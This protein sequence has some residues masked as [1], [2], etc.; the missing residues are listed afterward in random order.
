MGRLVED[1]KEA[2]RELRFA[3]VAG[4]A[5]LMSVVG[6][7]FL[8]SGILY[9]NHT[10]R[11]LLFTVSPSSVSLTVWGYVA[12][13]TANPTVTILQ[14]NVTAIRRFH[15]D[16][17]DDY[18]VPTLT[19][20]LSTMEEI[21]IEL[22]KYYGAISPI[23]QISAY[24]V[25]RYDTD[26]PIENA[27]KFYREIHPILKRLDPD[28]FFQME[29]VVLLSGGGGVLCEWV[30][31]NEA[32]DDDMLYTL[33]PLH[34]SDS[35]VAFAL[36]VA[37]PSD[38]YSLVELH[39]TDYTVRARGTD[40]YSFDRG[41]SFYDAFLVVRQWERYVGTVDSVWDACIPLMTKRV[42]N[43]RL[44]AY[45]SDVLSISEEINVRGT[46]NVFDCMEKLE[47]VLSISPS[48][49]SN[50]PVSR[51]EEQ[52]FRDCVRQN[53]PSF[54]RYLPGSNMTDAFCHFLSTAT[55]IDCLVLNT[56]APTV[57]TLNGFAVRYCNDIVFPCAF[58]WQDLRSILK[59]NEYQ[60]PPVVIFTGD[61]LEAFRVFPSIQFAF[62]LD[63]AVKLIY[64]ARVCNRGDTSNRTGTI[65][66]D[67]MFSLNVAKLGLG[68]AAVEQSFAFA[69]SLAE[70]ITFERGAAELV[71]TGLLTNA[72][73]EDA[74][75]LIQDVS[76]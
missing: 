31:M 19:R 27:A 65:C 42:G 69:S 66:F 14:H 61:A 45:L 5:F 32:L 72:N 29:N 64:D 1:T 8:A 18:T 41:R 9:L 63:D 33:S 43:V 38:S 50:V 73:F 16:P 52:L 55:P 36:E 35:S 22:E 62:N 4:Y 49:V 6:V 10:H 56:C 70:E 15:T 39:G 28:L 48:A 74:A 37:K 76:A 25:V 67:A 54:T 58:H 24:V 20:I 57:E 68:F 17:Y 75:D 46:G 40:L 13:A 60:T 44:S 12:G 71:L 26:L 53:M 11:A 23:E 7:A 21:C 34:I 30:G 3:L 51:R 59:P 2:L 47:E